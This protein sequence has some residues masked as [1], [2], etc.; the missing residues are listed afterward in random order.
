MI[1]NKTLVGMASGI[2]LMML[3]MDNII[4]NIDLMMNTS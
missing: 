2:G 3:N 1:N 4:D